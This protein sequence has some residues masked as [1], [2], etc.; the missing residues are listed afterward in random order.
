MIDTAGCILEV[1]G[2][3]CE[4]LGYR[5]DELIGRSVFSFTHPDADP[6]SWVQVKEVLT[7]TLDNVRLASVSHRKDGNT[8]WTDVVLSLVRDA[9]GTP[10]FAV[11]MVED[12]T[13]RQRLE[14]RLRHQAQH[15]PLTGLPNRTLF[16]ERLEAAL[17]D[18]D[19]ELGRLLPRP[20]RLQGRQR[21][22]RPRHRRPLLQA[23]ADRLRGRGRPCTWWPGWAA[24]S[25]WC[26]SSIRATRSARHR[27][28]PLRADGPVGGA[29]ADPARRPQLMVSASAGVVQRADVG[30][31]AAELMQAADTT[32]YW[33]K[34]DGRN[35]LALFDA[36]RHHRD[37]G[38]FALSA[39]MPEALARGEFAVEYQPLVRL[40]D[41]SGGRGRG[42]GAL[43]PAL[44]RAAGAGPVHPAGRGD[45]ADRAA[46]PLG[47]RRDLPAGR[48]VAARGARDRA[49]RQ[50]QPGGPPGARAGHGRRRGRASWP[51]PAGRRT[52]CRWS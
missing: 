31:G 11:G 17:A 34:E 20:R 7:G 1:N 51:R 27:A 49:V 19:R 2:A 38:R 36:E 22:P 26:W 44:R 30:A 21:H 4:L 39:R 41:A 13:D 48:R 28:E 32:L 52:R 35:R 16:F 23:V 42:A 47:A 45:R 50:R 9:D 12:T 18:P 14:D 37:V 5:A 24:T 33:A 3:L 40:S 6:T 25:S 8:V 43:G 46:R 15:D 29:P 10:R